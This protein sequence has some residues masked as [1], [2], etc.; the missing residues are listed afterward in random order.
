MRFHDAFTGRTERARRR[1]PRGRRRHQSSR[2]LGNGLARDRF[3]NPLTGSWKTKAL[4]IDRLNE[5]SEFTNDGTKEMVETIDIFWI[6][7][8]GL[9]GHINHRTVERILDIG[10]NKAGYTA[11]EVTCGWA[12]AIFEVT[13]PFGQEQ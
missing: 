3:A 11:T 1:L 12:G 5:Y 10:M 9:K 6:I 7:H 2:S 4:T 8:D 13:R